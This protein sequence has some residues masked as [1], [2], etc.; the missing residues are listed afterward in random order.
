VG[1]AYILCG[2]VAVSCPE[3]FG[4]YVDMVGKTRVPSP[5]PRLAVGL[6][7]LMT[8]VCRVTGKPALLTGTAVRGLCLQATY[9]GDKARGE[10]GF[11]AKTDL[12]TDMRAVKEWLEKTRQLG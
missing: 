9:D 11:E 4:H 5:P 1:E 7:R 10:L 8:G 6:A 12:E 2:P 3:F